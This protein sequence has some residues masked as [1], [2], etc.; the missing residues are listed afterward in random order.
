MLAPSWELVRDCKDGKI[1]KEEYTKIYTESILA[2]LPA[3]ELYTYIESK[4]PVGEDITLLCYEKPSDFC[5]RHL[6]AD[7]F[8]QAGFPVTEMIF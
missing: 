4:F 6:V 7:W 2:P 8:T 1:S 5:H 3:K